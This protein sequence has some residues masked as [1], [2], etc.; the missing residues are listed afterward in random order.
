MIKG[1]VFLHA[2]LLAKRA[3]MVIHIS[4]FLISMNPCRQQWEQP[5]PKLLAL[6]MFWTWERAA[7]E[8]AGG[9]LAGWIP[10]ACC[11][12]NAMSIPHS[13]AAFPEASDQLLRVATPRQSPIQIANLGV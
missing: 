3:C 12:P 4:T 1:A 10:P 6:Q 9:W 5:M 7:G 11:V 8:Q 13:P 2:A